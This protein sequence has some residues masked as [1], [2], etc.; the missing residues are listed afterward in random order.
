MTDN[1]VAPPRPDQLAGIRWIAFDAVGTL[2]YPDPP[3]AEIYHRVAARHGSS[4]TRDETGRRFSTAFDEVE[5][6]ALDSC[7][8]ATAHLITSETIEKARWQAIVS[9]VIGDAADPDRCFEELFAH[10]AQPSAWRCFPEVAGVLARLKSAGYM[11]AAAS[12]FDDRLTAI[13][14]ELAG[15]AP[16]DLLVISS[17]VGFRK[18]SPRFYD[19]LIAATGARRNEVLMVGD[20]LENDYRGAR[21]A[22]LLAMH[23]DRN[24]GGLPTLADAESLLMQSRTGQ[25][26]LPS[27]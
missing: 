20:D 19:E 2:I 11:L 14:R 9:R 26:S 21:S 3:V 25:R 18:P 12:N 6:Q 15:L 27:R 7:E 24:G 10:F 8:A 5:R 1:P 4:L 17:Q 22:G 23:I 13:S 16:L